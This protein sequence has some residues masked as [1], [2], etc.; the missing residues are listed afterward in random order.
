MTI[1]WSLSLG[2]LLTIITIIIG[3]YT[4][5]T[6]LLKKH[7]SELKNYEKLV[8]K[9]DLLYEWFRTNVI[10]VSFEKGEN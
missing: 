8:N 2:N 6:N 1:N 10:N 4:I 5:H 3:L 7:D 9:V